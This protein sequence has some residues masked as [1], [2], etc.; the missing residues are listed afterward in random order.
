MSQRIFKLAL[1]VRNRKLGKLLVRVVTLAIIKLRF[2][3]RR[4]RDVYMAELA[5]LFGIRGVV[6]DHAVIGSTWVTRLPLWSLIPDIRPTDQPLELEEGLRKLMTEP[7]FA[8]V[9]LRIGLT[10]ARDMHERPAV[11]NFTMPV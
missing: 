8:V 2:R 9:A 11:L 3:I 6:A 1:L 4:E 5:V 7:T 10:K